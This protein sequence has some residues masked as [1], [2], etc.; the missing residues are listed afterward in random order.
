MPPAGDRWEHIPSAV[1]ARMLDPGTVKLT[2]HAPSENGDGVT[3]YRIYRKSTGDA[4]RLGDSYRDHVLVAYSSGN[5][6][7]FIDHTVEVGVTYEYGV[8]AYRDGYPNPMGPISH[9]A[10]ARPWE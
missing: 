1:D 2:W 3:N 5:S 10:Y 8:A 4:R 7:S 9:R 6:T